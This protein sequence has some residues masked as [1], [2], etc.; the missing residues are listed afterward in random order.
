MTSVAQELGQGMS[1]EDPNSRFVAV[2]ERVARCFAT[3]HNRALRIVSPSQ[4]GIASPL[5]HK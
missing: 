3:A 5:R 2:R 4:F 1:G